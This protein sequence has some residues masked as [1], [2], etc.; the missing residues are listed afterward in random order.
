MEIAGITVGTRE[1][2]LLLIAVIA[3]YMAF[4]ALRMKRLLNPLK[5]EAATPPK[6]QAAEQLTSTIAQEA[7][8]EP[9]LDWHRSSRAMAEETLR[10]GLEQ[11]LLQL[12]EEV[13]MLRGELAALRQDMRNEI[14]QMR[15]SQT[16]SPIYGDAMQLALAGYD[17]QAISERCGIARAE[18]EL[19]VALAQRRES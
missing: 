15:A 12:R 1:L 2:L 18:A 6:A 8:I 11:E 17:T 4:V 10:K 14:G 5:A 19:V 16:V 7:P 13:D 3:G 9:A